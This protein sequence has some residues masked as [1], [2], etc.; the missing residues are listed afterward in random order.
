MKKI[1]LSEK[2][3]NNYL[4]TNLKTRVEFISYVSDQFRKLVKRN[5]RIPI[6]MYQL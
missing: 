5:L 4:K 6:Q 1:I 2:S 3:K